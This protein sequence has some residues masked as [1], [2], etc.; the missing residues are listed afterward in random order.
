MYI[1]RIRL[2]EKASGAFV[3]SAKAGLI[4]RRLI[5]ETWESVG[6][7]GPYSLEIEGLEGEDLKREEHLQRVMKSLHHLKQIGLTS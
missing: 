4:F 1:Q 7:D 6:F 2:G 5:V 3:R